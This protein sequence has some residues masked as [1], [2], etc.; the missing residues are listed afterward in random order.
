MI[1]VIIKNDLPVFLP[2]DFCLIQYT[3][4]SRHARTRAYGSVRRVAPSV[5]YG[6]EER[7]CSPQTAWVYSPVSR[8]SCFPP[9]YAL[10]HSRS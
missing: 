5:C 4:Q 2:E 7:I 1:F 10:R 6:A 3:L 8:V 9:P